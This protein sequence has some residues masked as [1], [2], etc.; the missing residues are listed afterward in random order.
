MKK[1]QIMRLLKVGI[2]TTIILLVFEII[3]SLDIINNFFLGLI[4]GANG[5]LAYLFVWL[6][7]FLQVTVLN[8][9]AYSILAACTSI[10]MHTLDIV[11]ISV[12]LS[13]YMTGAILAYWVGRWFGKRAVKWCAGSEDDYNKW[14]NVLNSKGKWWYFA[15]IVFPFFPDDLLCLVTGATRFHFGLFCGMNFVGRGIGLV[16][17]I[18]TLQLITKVSGGFSFMIIVWAVALLAEVIAYIII[19]KRRK[20]EKE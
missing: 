1:D 7:M 18:L 13:A 6:I 10:E 19:N 20:H 12:V 15:T 9:P 2:V 8:I 16:T 11:F 17:T 5:W 4:S 14:S 3:F